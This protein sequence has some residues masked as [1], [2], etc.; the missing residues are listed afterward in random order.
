MEYGVT[1][2]MSNSSLALGLS[3]TFSTTI[4]LQL[5]LE[6]FRKT[7]VAKGM[8]TALQ[9]IFADPKWVFPGGFER[10]T[11]SFAA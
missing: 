10:M 8:E 5:M 4:Y 3:G 2:L 6:P 9:P 7:F 11:R 1:Y